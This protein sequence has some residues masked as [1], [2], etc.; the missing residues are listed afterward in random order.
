MK[1]EDKWFDWSVT[2]EVSVSD[3]EPGL[4]M[5]ELR[6]GE[7]LAEHPEMADVLIWFLPVRRLRR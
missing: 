1:C 7:Y 6:K 5:V 2:G 3:E 4:D